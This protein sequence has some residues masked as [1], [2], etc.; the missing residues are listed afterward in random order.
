MTDPS[1][2]PVLSPMTTSMTAREEEGEEEVE[3]V[4]LIDDQGVEWTGAA[5]EDDDTGLTWNSREG[6]LIRRGR[7]DSNRRDEIYTPT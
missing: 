6:A 7:R 4:V 5:L 3:N 2:L 1:H